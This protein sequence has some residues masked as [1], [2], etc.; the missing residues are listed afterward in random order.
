MKIEK[1]RLHGVFGTIILLKM[2]DLK[3][4]MYNYCDL[5]YKI[6]LLTDDY[7]NKMDYAGD[8]DNFIEEL[9]AKAEKIHLTLIRHSVNKENFAASRDKYEYLE[10][11]FFLNQLKDLC[12][13]LQMAGKQPEAVDLAERFEKEHE[14]AFAYI[15]MSEKL[16]LKQTDPTAFVYL[17]SVFSKAKDID[18]SQLNFGASQ[19]IDFRFNL[20]L[21]MSRIGGKQLNSLSNKYLADIIEQNKFFGVISRVYGI[22]EEGNFYRAQMAIPST[23]TETE[24]LTAR[25][26]IVWQA[27][28]KKEL[29][30]GS[31][32][33]A[34]MDDFFTHDFNY[35]FYIPN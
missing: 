6:F 1:Y 27:C 31:K 9:N 4:E 13:N 18:F 32:K 5:K 34:A 20:I 30:E 21:L 16:Y 26:N 12:I 23:L 28:R 11:T 17:D 14:K 19:A 24:D 8:I 15:F 10:K 7:S 29:E 25:A 3:D 2:G 33:W 35:I 22:A